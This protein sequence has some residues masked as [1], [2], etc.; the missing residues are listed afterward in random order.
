MRIH[1]TFLRRCIKTLETAPREIERHRE[2]DESM[3]WF[4]REALHRESDAE[5]ALPMPFSPRKHP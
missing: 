1:T 4:S 5:P 3:W 2:S